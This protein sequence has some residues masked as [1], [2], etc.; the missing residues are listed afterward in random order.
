[1]GSRTGLFQ[2]LP[3][4][5]KF[6]LFK[7]ICCQNCDSFSCKI[8]SHDISSMNWVFISFDAARAGAVY[9]ESQIVFARI[10]GCAAAHIE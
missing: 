6:G 8:T 5:Q 9:R 4:F 1:L 3:G 10:A 7:T 2:S